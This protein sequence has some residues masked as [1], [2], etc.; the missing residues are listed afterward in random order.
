MLISFSAVARQML[1]ART[2]RSRGIVLVGAHMCSFDLSLLAAAGFFPTMQALSKANPEGSSP[3]MNDIRAGYGLRITPLSTNTLRQAIDALRQGG[4][5]AIAADIP[6]A[7]GEELHFFGQKARLGVG[8]ARLAL[9]TGSDIVVAVPH[10]TGEGRYR[11]EASPVARPA[12]SGCRKQDAIRLA[13][14]TLLKIEAYIRRWP[15]QWFMPQPVWPE[16]HQMGII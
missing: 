7:D 9:T 6:M 16:Y 3:V 11:M 8:H 12:A 4:I 2:R 5:V 13:Q 10:Q 1:L 15:D 14:A